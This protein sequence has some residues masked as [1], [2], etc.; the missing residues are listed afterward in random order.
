MRGDFNMSIYPNTLNPEQVQLMTLLQENVTPHAHDYLELVYITQGEIIHT[1]NES[2]NVVRQG[3]FFIIDYHTHH[4]Y[5]T[6]PDNSCHLTNCLFLPSL[7]DPTLKDCKSFETLINNHLIHFNNNILKTNP[8]NYVFHDDD[9]RIGT[10]FKTLVHEYTKKTYGYI[11]MIRSKLIEILILTMR[12]IIKEEAA[13]CMDETISQVLS[14]IDA[15]YA[16]E[17]TLTSLSRTLNYSLP[18]LS[19]KFKR[20]M[21]L[22]F[23]EYLQ[24]IRI[25]QSCRLLLNTNKSIHEIAE[26]VG[27]HDI[28]FYYTVFKRLLAA[29]PREFRKLYQN[30]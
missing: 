22:P 29:T 13:A 14:Y 24:K 20:A 23:S 5:T 25:E 6:L 7:I 27:Y 12:K 10:L 17:I 18:Y 21:G 11:E 4:S 1:V 30:R 15:H 3:D 26:L 16:Q 9:G 2:E 28:N 19:L 8:A